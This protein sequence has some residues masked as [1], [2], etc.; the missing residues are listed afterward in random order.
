MHNKR[1]F[2]RAAD[3]PD[4]SAPSLS[5]WDNLRYN[6]LH[7]L[8]YYTRGVTTRNRF[9]VAFWARVHPDPMGVRF[10]SAL[11]KKYRSDYL[12]LLQIATKSLVV[13]DPDGIKRV[14]DHSPDI[15]A[16]PR[17]KHKTMSH[18]QPGAVTI[19]RGKAWQERRRFNE[20]VLHSGETLHPYAGHFLA[21]IRREVAASR[22]AFRPRLVWEDVAD[23]FERITLQVVFGE[24]NHDV[25][26]THA[27]TRMMQESNRV[28]ALRPSRW[29]DGFHAQL[30]TYLAN[31]APGSLTALC[32]HAPST[33]ET[34]VP[35]Q[36]THWVFAMK[37]TLAE[38]VVY[39]LAL[40][41][42]HPNVEDRVRQ[43]LA[44]TDLAAPE[45]VQA[46][47]YLE[48]CI[49]EA[50]RLW[51]SIPQIARETVGQDTLDPTVV[52]PATQVLILNSFNHRD[53][54][55]LPSADVFNPERWLGQDTNYTFNHFSNGPQACVGKD[56]ALFIAKAV[57][58]SLLSSGRY[59]LVKP[60]L[61]Q[62]AP[63]AYALN[64]FGVVFAKTENIR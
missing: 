17:L 55:R 57:L 36:I 16:E 37:D 21:V 40:I 46:L 6:V 22:A 64:H 14:L 63:L 44:H 1:R 47:T 8:P 33:D 49:Q 50:M 27:L 3:P 30:R 18:F 48:A 9:W 19:S 7:V 29:F 53:R 24:G 52:P 42:S 10:F 23:L 25:A 58:A 32:R 41:A 31:P 59:L 13:L 2:R 60:S 56:L 4:N 34:H 54:E 51:P 12:Y 5:F 20:A 62:N 15:Y 39:A 28:F 26:L 45:D 35:S 38:N 43:E 11:R 61:R